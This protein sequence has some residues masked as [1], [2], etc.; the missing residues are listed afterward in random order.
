MALTY[1]YGLAVLADI[2][3]I[4]SATWDIRRADELSGSGDGRVWQAELADPL[5]TA[6]V[7]LAPRRH[8]EM[9]RI[10]ALIR[11]LHGAQEAFWLTDPLSPYPQADPDGSVLGAATV[12]VHSVGSERRTLRLKGLPAGYQLTLGD[13]G[14]IAFSSDP[15]E[16]FFFEFSESSAADGSGITAEAEVFPF[17]PAGV[18]AD[19][20]ATL[21]KPACKMFVMPGSHNPGRAGRLLTDGQ[22]FTAME[23]RR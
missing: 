9:K 8:G 3:P 7:T 2:L 15:A 17:V 4:R 13:K 5:W 11:K 23:R 18:A 1:P 20:A 19:D 10:A 14:Q 6:T 21:A 16:T 12:Q 22:S